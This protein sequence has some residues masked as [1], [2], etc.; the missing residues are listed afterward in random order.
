MAIKALNQLILQNEVSFLLNTESMNTQNLWGA[1]ESCE[2]QVRSSFLCAAHTVPPWD[3]TASWPS[4]WWLHCD[5]KQWKRPTEPCR[6]WFSEC[7]WSAQSNQPWN[8]KCQL[9]LKKCFHLGQHSRLAVCR[10]GLKPLH[11]EK[12]KK[13][14]LYYTSQQEGGIVTSNPPSWSCHLS[15]WRAVTDEIFPDFFSV[16]AVSYAY[17]MEHL[18]E[19]CPA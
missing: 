7:L 16:Q 5:V 4:H 15:G 19:H 12:H 6:K 10:H 17:A 13:K 2:S 9:C 8:K 1:E 11:L 14:G 18:L 3:L